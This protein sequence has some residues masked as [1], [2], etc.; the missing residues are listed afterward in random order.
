MFNEIVNQAQPNQ[1]NNEKNK[2]NKKNN[3]I[4]IK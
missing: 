3:I 2:K 4:L 1:V